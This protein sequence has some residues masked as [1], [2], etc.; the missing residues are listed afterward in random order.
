[1]IEPGEIY[2]ADL[3]EQAPHPIIVVSREGLN[4][5]DR[6][7]AVLCTSQKFATRSGLPH[8]VPFHAGQFGFSKDCVAQC[9]NI[10]LVAKSDLAPSPLGALDDAALRDVIKA[11]GHVLDSDHEPN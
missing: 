3:G 1:M 5:G 4:R 9:E 10:F 2:M 8:C 11:I 7:V 6:V